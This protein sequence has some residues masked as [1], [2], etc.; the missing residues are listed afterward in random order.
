MSKWKLSL[1]KQEDAQ[2]FIRSGG[3]CFAKIG[4]K[5]LGKLSPFQRWLFELASDECMEDN[6]REGRGDIWQIWKNPSF[7][8]PGQICEE[9]NLNE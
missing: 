3:I 2:I 6:G 7:Q 5:E 8:S 4:I 9:Y 1:R